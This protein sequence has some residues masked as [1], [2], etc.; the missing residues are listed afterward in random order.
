LPGSG[1]AGFEIQIFAHDSGNQRAIG[2][3][4]PVTGQVG[5]IAD[6]NEGFVY[7]DGLGSDRED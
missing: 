3:D 7:G 1:F 6:R 5:Q 4:R 2:P